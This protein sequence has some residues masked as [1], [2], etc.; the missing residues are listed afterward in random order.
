MKVISAALH[1]EACQRKWFICVLWESALSRMV[2]GQLHLQTTGQCVKVSA[3]R[4]IYVQPGVWGG[5][6][7]RCMLWWKWVNVFLY[8]ITS[9]VT[10]CAG[11]CLW[12]IDY[13]DA[14]KGMLIRNVITIFSSVTIYTWCNWLFTCA[15]ARGHLGGS[16]QYTALSCD[17]TRFAP[18]REFRLPPL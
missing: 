11:Y 18:F 10:V 8:H 6:N 1:V 3:L 17:L 13:L 7:V 4:V 5:S 2:Y 12:I 9:F 14:V 15:Y 16:T